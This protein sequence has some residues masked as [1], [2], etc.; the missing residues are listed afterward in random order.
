MRFAD[1]R[2]EALEAFLD[3]VVLDT[4]GKKHVRNGPNMFR[5][6]LRTMAKED[7][8]HIG[9]AHD[10][11]HRGREGKGRFRLRLGRETKSLVSNRFLGVHAFN[12][13]LETLLYRRVDRDNTGKRIDDH[14]PNS[15]LGGSVGTGMI[16]AT[17]ET[18]HGNRGV[19]KETCKVGFTGKNEIKLH[20]GIVVMLRIEVMRCND[21]T[22]RLLAAGIS[23]A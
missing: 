14:I 16:T 17:H 2:R 8:L 20:S 4:I 22:A 12:E 23:A 13:S 6:G 15:L 5:K 7:L 3:F 9:L 1:R 18:V 19:G 10:E 11:F 21:V